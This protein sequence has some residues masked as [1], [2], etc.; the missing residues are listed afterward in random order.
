LLTLP[1]SHIQV[2]VYLILNIFLIFW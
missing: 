1:K 2:Q